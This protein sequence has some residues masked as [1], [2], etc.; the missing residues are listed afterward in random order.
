MN[1]PGENKKPQELYQSVKFLGFLV[2]K[3]VGICKLCQLFIQFNY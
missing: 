1:K 3:I 2:G